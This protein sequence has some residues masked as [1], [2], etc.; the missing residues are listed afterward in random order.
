M[1]LPAFTSTIHVCCRKD[2]NLNFLAMQSQIELK[3]G[4]DL[5][6]VS[7]ISIHVLVLRL[8]FVYIL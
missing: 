4:G 3:L 5:G 7:Q 2:K 1:V 6:L 8:L